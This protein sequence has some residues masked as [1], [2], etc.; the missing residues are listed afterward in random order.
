MHARQPRKKYVLD[1]FCF[2][3]VNKSN[4][5]FSDTNQT[6]K[7]EEIV[8]VSGTIVKGGWIHIWY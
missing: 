6:N 5:K 2:L 8:H 7:Q 4:E 1:L 3:I